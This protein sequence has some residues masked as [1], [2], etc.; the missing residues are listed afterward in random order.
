[1][2]LMPC[3]F[4]ATAAQAEEGARRFV[5]AGYR[6]IK[7]RLY[8]DLALDV[9]VVGAVRRAF[10]EGRLLGD[11]NRGYRSPAAAREAM[12]ALG[13]AGLSVAEDILRGSLDAYAELCREFAVPR[14]MVDA[15]SRGWK[16]L[17]KTCKK[18]AAHEINIHANCQGT[19]SEVLARAA[20]AEAAGIVTAVG[21]VGYTG[22]GA[23]AYA[24]VASVVGLE[25]P[26]GEQGGAFD[27]GLAAS[28][29]RR[30]LVVRD[31]DLFLPEGPGHGGEL[32]LDAIGPYITETLEFS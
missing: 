3:V 9:A 7:T 17:R 15:R 6:A 31:G 8:G 5:D 22:I 27:A 29:A 16:G 23:Y 13:E 25:Q 11:A 19:M 4:P 20:A 24:H 12:R 2:P 26:H 1:M 10:P 30:P 32:D 21:G 18:K 14:V 28:S